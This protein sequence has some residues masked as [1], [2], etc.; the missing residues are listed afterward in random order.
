MEAD[1]EKV[2]EQLMATL[3]PFQVCTLHRSAKN[4]GTYICQ[5][6]PLSSARL[7]CI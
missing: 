6:A 3:L 4:N 7:W 5:A 1:V 2:Q